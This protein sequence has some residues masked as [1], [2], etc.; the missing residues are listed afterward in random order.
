MR[1]VEVWVEPLEDN[2]TFLV[3]VAD[4]DEAAKRVELSLRRHRLIKTPDQMQVVSNTLVIW[5]AGKVFAL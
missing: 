3:N 2:R 5:D 1:I 4:S